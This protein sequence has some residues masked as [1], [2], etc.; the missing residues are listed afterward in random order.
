MVL[1][2]YTLHVDYNPTNPGS[3]DLKKDWEKW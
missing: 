2:G 3:I 1:A